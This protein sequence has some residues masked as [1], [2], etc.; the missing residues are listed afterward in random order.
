MPTVQSLETEET[1][2]S[3]NQKTYTLKTK[4]LTTLN[5]H[6]VIDVPQARGAVLGDRHEDAFA[7]HRHD[8]LC[9]TKM[10]IHD[11]L[12]MTERHSVYIHVCVC[13]CVCVRVYV[14]VC[15]LSIEIMASV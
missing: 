3:L 2:R 7:R 10:P 6:L 9:V 13:V 15:I 12:W 14:C 1:M 8:G 5:T 4:P 11:H